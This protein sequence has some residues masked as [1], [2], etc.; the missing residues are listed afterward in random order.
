[1]SSGLVGSICTGP[2]EPPYGISGV[3][4]SRE[5]LKR[6]PYQAPG[7]SEKRALDT[8]PVPQ[9]T[10]DILFESLHAIIS[11]ESARMWQMSG[12]NHKDL[13]L[14]SKEVCPP[15]MHYRIG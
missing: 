10:E 14:F 5:A 15:I 1:V 4:H 13:E 12:C 9:P 2:S 11:M 8:K 3:S 6:R 7:P